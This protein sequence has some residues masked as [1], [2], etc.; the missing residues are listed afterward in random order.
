MLFYGLVF[1]ITFFVAFLYWLGL[2]F[3]R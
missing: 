3:A 1:A 2:Y